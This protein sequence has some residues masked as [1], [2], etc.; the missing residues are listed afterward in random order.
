[1]NR[2]YQHCF[3]WEGLLILT[4]KLIKKARLMEEI[5]VGRQIES[6]IY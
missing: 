3:S 5:N 6:S 1:M 2:Y 4:G